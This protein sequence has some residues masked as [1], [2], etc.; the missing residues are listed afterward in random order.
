[1]PSG[2]F[3]TTWVSHAYI[4]SEDGKLLYILNGHKDFILSIEVFPDGR[5][6]TGSRDHT[7]RIWSATGEHLTTLQGRDEIWCVKLLPNGDILTGGMDAKLRLWSIDTDVFVQASPSQRAA[8][9]IS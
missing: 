9:A 7:V 8:C 2:G 1:M 5:I 3:V 4:W 6:V